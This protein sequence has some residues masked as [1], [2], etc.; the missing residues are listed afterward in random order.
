MRCLNCQKKGIPLS[1]QLCPK[2]GVH[3]PSLMRDV[4]P[5]GTR[6]QGG[7][8][9][10]DFVLGRGGFGITYQA[11]HTALEKQVAIKEFY[12]QEHAL[13]E[14]ATGG[15]MVPTAKQE[16]YQRGKKR[17][18]QEGKTLAKLNHS[19]VVRVENFFEERGTAYLVME[20]ITGNTLREELDAQ[21]DKRFSSAQ[22]ETIM[23]ALVGALSAVHEQ[24]I[25]HLDLKPDNVL[26][27]PEGR[28]VLVDF[29]ASRQGLSV[30]TT[31]QAFTLDYAPP[32]VI[33][34]RDFS[35]A[36]DLF[37]LGMM[38][39]EML[40]GKLP[41]RSIDRILKDSWEGTE[42][43]EPWRGL[44]TSALRLHK[45]ERPQSVQ[46][47]WQSGSVYHSLVAGNINQVS[48]NLSRTQQTPVG[49]TQLVA[50]TK[51]CTQCGNS[52]PNSNKFC[53][54]CG[55]ALQ[56][57]TSRELPLKEKVEELHPDDWSR[58]KKGGFWGFLG[59]LLDDK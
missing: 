26:V 22:V 46:K 52:N 24:G 2:C 45:E 47:W 33:A 56:A 41:P 25:Y 1:T 58:Q 35:A 57:T 6:L 32:E 39:H 5:H 28:L 50:T 4:L 48:Q 10:L 53:Q 40:T 20:L 37:E 27:T 11:I 13:R 30:G 3:L 16:I 38:L 19:N 36:S 9:S 42:L 29:G 8:Y 51:I 44:L 23:S 17:F 34:G 43:Q 31:S 18:L 49:E 21:P 55:T 54:N 14:D 7:T 59:S 12:P 15:L